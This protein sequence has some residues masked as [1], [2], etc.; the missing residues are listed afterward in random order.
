MLTSLIA[1]LI[2]F[3]AAYVVA[4]SQNKMQDRR[5]I[6]ERRLQRLQEQY[7]PLLL[8][9]AAVINQVRTSLADPDSSLDLVRLMPYAERL[10]AV[11]A[12]FVLAPHAM[13][14]H[15]AF[16]RYRIAFETLL[17]DV[18][19]EGARL[20][21]QRRRQHLAALEAASGD[22]ARQMSDEVFD[23]EDR[24]FRL[25]VLDILE[26]LP[27][28]LRTR[29]KGKAAYAELRKLNEERTK[30]AAMPPMR[31]SDSSD[32]QPSGACA[33]A[34]AFA[35]AGAGLEVPTHRSSHSEPSPN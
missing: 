22:T 34:P 30:V 2:A 9:M 26:M 4:R 33:A 7:K 29:K 20:S 1:A 32:Q 23:L 35:P 24:L 25:G 11:E 15:V 6:V 21:E 28:A 5:L 13:K 12:D 27:G 19:R 17:T 8:D 16:L 3:V 10:D 18:Q 31:A 14:P